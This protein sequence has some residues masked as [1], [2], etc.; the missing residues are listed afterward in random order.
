MSVRAQYVKSTDPEVVRIITENTEKRLAAHQAALEWAARHG[1]TGYYG[2]RNFGGAFGVWAIETDQKPTT[3]QWKR[4]YRGRG[5]APF[6]SNP[7]HTEMA[8][9]TVGFDSVPGADG[10]FSAPRGSGDG[11]E[12]WMMWAAPFVVDGVAFAM[13][14]NY[15]T[16]GEFGDQWAEIKASEAYAAKES[17]ESKAVAA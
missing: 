4:G 2:G 12:T 16:E 8:A 5:W 17:Y 9:L 3:G 13:L 15:P 11:S 10:C 1:G 14:S 7:I 6:K